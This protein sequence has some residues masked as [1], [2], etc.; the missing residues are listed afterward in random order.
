MFAETAIWQPR[1]DPPIGGWP[2]LLFLHGC[3]GTGREHTPHAR[4]A[5]AQGLAAVAIPGPVAALGGGLAW[6]AD[7][8]ETTHAYLQRALTGC[9]GQLPLNRA[10]PLL[11]GFSQGATHV[12]GLLA[13]HPDGY[14]GGIALSPGEGPPIPA[15]NQTRSAQPPLCVTYGA[16]DFPAFRKKARR[17]SRAWRRAGWPCL[18]EAHAGSHQMPQDWGERFPR[19]LRWLGERGTGLAD[20]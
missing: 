1:C 13:T 7:G 14:A 2:V 17:C 3:G 16:R 12:V 19:M 8:F 15:P 18:L 9:G 20:A 11:C 6:P 10:R 4:A 5:T